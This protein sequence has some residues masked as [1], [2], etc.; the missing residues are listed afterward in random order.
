MAKMEENQ[1]LEAQRAELKMKA[2]CFT[3]NVLKAMV[4]ENTREIY[5]SLNI[6]EMKVI[7]IGG[8]DG[9]AQDPAGQLMG[10]ML[11]SY[12]AISSEMDK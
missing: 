7:N 12:K 6:P 8:G 3:P 1:T 10:Q 9:K 4:I 5:K 11:A 2:E